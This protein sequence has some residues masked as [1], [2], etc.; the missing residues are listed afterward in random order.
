[1]TRPL[2]DLVLGLCLLL[3]VA[4]LAQLARAQGVSASLKGTVEATPGD[5]SSQVELVPGATITLANR[6]LSSAVF[7]T[8]SDDTGSFAFRDLPAGNYILS[9]EA[10]GF[11]RITREIRL[12]GGAAVTVE[13]ILTPTVSE[14]VTVRDE[15]GLLSL[16]ETATSNTI[17]AEKLEE[18]PLRADNYLGAL[19][20]T[21]GIIRTVDGRD[22]I[23]GTGAGQSAYTVNG[24]DITDP[25]NGNVAFDIP[26]EAAANVHI[27]DNPYSAEFGRTTGGASNLETK[28]G[29]NK[30]EFHSARVFPVFHSV[31]GG[32]LDSFRP[33][34]T[35]EGPLIKGRLTFLQSFEYRFSRIYV[36]SL[37]A[38]N[39]NSTDE[40][41]NSFTQFDLSINRNNLLKFNGAIFPEK[42]RFVGLNTFNPRETTPDIKQRGTLISVSEQSIFPDQSF[43]T[44]L[45]AYKTFHLDVFGRDN[46]PLILRPDENS[47]SY[48]ADTRR[49]AQRWQWQEQYFLRAINFAG[50]HSLKLGGELDQTTLSGR[51]DFRP[52]EIRRPDQTLSERIQFVGPTF[53]DR[54]LTEVGMFA[55]DRWVMNRK[56]TLDGGL[57]LD[58][59]NI[60]RQTDFSPRLSLLYLPGND[61]RTVIRGGVGIFFDRSPLSNRSFEPESL[62]DSDDDSINN[63]PPQLH[64]TNFPARIITTYA[65]DGQTIIDGPRSFMNL[66][67]I[68]LEDA[69]GIRWSTQ[70]DRRVG[71]H[72]TLRGGYLH[73]F[74]Q[75]LPI[76]IPKS[77]RNGNGLLILKSSGTARYN[78]F[79][80]LALYDSDRFHNWTVSYVWSRARG[81]LN[82]SDN[83]LGDLPAVVVRPNAYATLPFDVPHRFLAY[84]E[85]KVPHGIVVMPALEVR[86]GLAYSF[87][88][89]RLNYVGAP[90]RARFPAYVS[91]DTTILKSFRVP[92]LDKTAR[93]GVIIFN[94]TNHFNPRDVQNNLSSLNA[95]RF[96]NSLGTSVRGKF[97]LDF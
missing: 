56:L 62:N 71:R 80:L 75:D 13:I 15:E 26:L 38:P 81:S 23:K 63:L 35:F 30:F 68:P 78:E 96:F 91:L 43:L 16:G 48:F 83:I 74:T 9:A 45:L 51:F 85:I 55:Q 22:H 84:G 24:A 7:K 89:E 94:T 50:Q 1:M 44:S 33:R 19:P 36:P 12:A 86:S 72:L 49:S 53:I 92:F 61:D 59:N 17:R 21:P 69:H 58:R 29:G 40:A 2:L 67:R 11:P 39:D 88:D 25:V 14:S 79:Q 97:E 32:K 87:V 31:I 3:A 95:G 37:D 41:F 60:S 8:T 65:P 34:L 27:E 76:V 47:G 57:R 28:A 93:A 90:N 46:I 4:I 73:R 42:K 6:D 77:L 66:A 5:S 10:K 82:T 54:P 52:I 64:G 70:L 18:L 20:L